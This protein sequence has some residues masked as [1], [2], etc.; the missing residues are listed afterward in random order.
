[1]RVFDFKL[2]KVLWRFPHS[3]VRCS[4]KKGDPLWIKKNAFQQSCCNSQL[5]G[6]HWSCDYLTR[7]RG[8]VT[9]TRLTSACSYSET[10]KMNKHL[11]FFRDSKDDFH[12]GCEATVLFRTSLT[13]TITPYETYEIKDKCSQVK[14]LELQQKRL[15]GKSLK[16]T[17]WVFGCWST[18]LRRIKMECRMRKICT[19]KGQIKL[20]TKAK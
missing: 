14:I 17:T 12:S 19:R 11:F 18:S 1:M 7:V 16:E 20:R 8:A 10:L 15:L 5:T 4:R 6:N 13:R 2:A 3:P 9:N